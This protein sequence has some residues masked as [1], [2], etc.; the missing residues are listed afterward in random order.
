VPSIAATL[1]TATFVPQAYKIIRSRETAGVSL[2]MHV[3]F[4]AGVAF[5]FALGVIL[6][7]WPIMIANALTFVLTI[8]IVTTVLRI[9]RVQ[10]LTLPVRGFA[11]GD[12]SAC[13][14][15]KPNYSAI[16]TFTQLG[17]KWLRSF[18]SW[19]G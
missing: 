3:A 2:L 6:W 17:L 11:A 19:A 1:T 13:K 14:P 8:I 5:W 10:A 15:G 7:N 18:R 9:T 16:R 4:A 12:L